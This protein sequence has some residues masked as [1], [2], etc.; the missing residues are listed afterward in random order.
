MTQIIGTA[1]VAPP[2][3]AIGV[4]VAMATAWAMRGRR[5][6]HRRRA[7]SG[8]GERAGVAEDERLDRHQDQEPS[9]GEDQGSVDGEHAN[10]EGGD[11]ERDEGEAEPGQSAGLEPAADDLGVEDGQQD[12]SERG[13]GEEQANASGP[14]L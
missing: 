7:E 11:G 8:G 12:L 1:V 4:E 10:G 5:R 6:W 13:G 2:E 3:L 14:R 9:A